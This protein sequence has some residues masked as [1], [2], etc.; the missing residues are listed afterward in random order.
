MAVSMASKPYRDMDRDMDRDNQRQ[1]QT[2]ASNIERRV[3]K[4]LTTA[5]IAALRVGKVLADGAIRPG[6]GSLKIRKRQTTIGVAAEWL[7]EWSRPDGTVRMTLGRYASTEGAD[8]LTLAQARTEAAR[9]QGMVRSGLNPRAEREQQRKDAIELEAREA[10][11]AR[12]SE[13]QSFSAL[14]AAYVEHLRSKGKN[15]SAYDAENIFSNHIEK[16][17]EDLAAMPAA[18][19]TAVDI[20]RILARLVA[21]NVKNPKGRTALKLR[22]YAAA[23]FRLF[24]GAKID[25]M[26]PIVAHDF[27]LTTNPAA[28][29]PATKM[30][31]AYNRAGD[32]NLKANELSMFLNYLCAR[33]QDLQSLALWLQL[34]TG[35]QRIQ[36]LLRLT[37]GDVE[38]QTMVIRDGKGKRSKPRLHLIP[39]TPEVVE[40]VSRLKQVNPQ[41]KQLGR[42]TPLFLSRRSVVAP[43]TISGAVREISD[44]ISLAHPAI[45][46]FRAGDL[47]RTAETILAETLHVSQDDRA[48]LL[49]HGLGGVQG[50]HY[51]KGEHR[52]AKLN[53][54]RLWNDFISDLC[55]GEFDPSASSTTTF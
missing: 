45:T 41:M 35:G 43:E 14:L 11:E 8:G 40:V 13:T 32:R 36:Q 25:P 28:A 53:A 23:A 33:D 20:S 42:E 17:F 46:P 47:R 38:G 37:H 30:A 9:L 7:F 29:V 50:K 31:E 5:S 39:M 2:A 21:P 18:Q 16:P 15:E 44:A 48:Q 19:I 6:A 51:D 1:T 52:Q 4:P 27:G 54:L 10:A 34:V 49:S 3:T 55:I 12:K 24:I 22:S 26:A